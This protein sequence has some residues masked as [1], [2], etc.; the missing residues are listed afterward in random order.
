MNPK[1]FCSFLLCLFILFSCN[2]ESKIIEPQ[3]S[4][5]SNLEKKEP[6][7]QDN[8]EEKQQIPIGNL[9][10]DLKDSGG[11]QS[12]LQHAT[13]IDW[14]KKII[15]TATV[16]LEVKDFKKSNEAIH[17]TIRQFG[18]YI[19][20]EEQNLTDEKS[21][22][23]LSIKVPVEQFETMMNELAAGDTKVLERKI[24]SQDVTGEV[25]D[26][27]S[28]LEAKKQVR[29]KYLDFLKG[30]KNM[31]DV[32]KVQ[33]E[34]NGIQEEIEAAAGRVEYLS[35]QSAFSTINLSVYQPAPGFIP[36]D[37]SP[38]FLTRV[39]N[40]FKAGADW[41]ADL[42]VAFISVWPLLMITAGGIIVFKRL[43]YLKSNPQNP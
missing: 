17:N 9:K 7:F 16:L 5:L 14:D 32:L 12:L 31:E 11:T 30:S 22:T 27:R 35:H 23:I 24:T 3:D 4:A 40:A 43:K 42:L 41:I 18:G 36:V 26:T 21:E 13:H 38:S 39:S 10:Q 34:I 28:R 29:L 20:Q 6:P 33:G 1:L 8:K 37:I 2:Q 15:K 25:I 19:A